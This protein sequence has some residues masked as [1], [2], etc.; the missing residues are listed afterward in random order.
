MIYLGKQVLFSFCKL[1]IGITTDFGD[2]GDTDG[3]LRFWIQRLVE[4]NRV[5]IGHQPDISYLVVLIHC[6]GER[7]WIQYS[8][9]ATNNV[10]KLGRRERYKFIGGPRFRT[11]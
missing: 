8:N 2:F 1:I 11:S 4:L 7:G 9:F 6:D 3:R 5:L 10:R